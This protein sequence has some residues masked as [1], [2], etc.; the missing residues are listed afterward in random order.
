MV[1]QATEGKNPMTLL[2]WRLLR[3][4]LLCLPRRHNAL[5]ELLPGCLGR[6][7]VLASG[8]A[9]QIVEPVVD[10][11]SILRKVGQ[12]LPEPSPGPE[13]LRL[14]RPRVN[15]KGSTD[16]FVGVPLDV[17]HDEHRSIPLR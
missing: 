15:S 7:V 3:R 10:H 14:G 2:R 4:L 17:M 12:L 16:L 6:V 8:I 1:A 5:P 13:Q 11:S 9:Q